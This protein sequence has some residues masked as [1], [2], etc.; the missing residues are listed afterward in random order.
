MIE[1]V[2]PPTRD[3]FMRRY[4]R[5]RVPVVITGAMADWPARTLWSAEHLKRVFGERR[6]PVAR[7]ADRRLLH[8]P[9]TGIPYDEMRFGEYLD[10]LTTLGAAGWYMMFLVHESLPELAHDVR[11]PAFRPDAPWSIH[12]F[13]LSP[14]D[15]RSP[16]HQDLP[17]NLFAQVVGRKKVTLYSPVETRK[18]YRH[19]LYSKLPPVSRVDPEAP[20]HHRFPRFR[21]AHATT[22]VLEPGEMLYIPR[23]WWH[24][25]RSLDFSVSVNDW[26]AVGAVNWV[27]QAALLY[28]KVRALRY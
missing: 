19:P 6:V 7:T 22:L 3:Q 17:E 13:W 10:R 23:L 21:D 1:R 9:K 24:Q 25:M 20:D 11:R 2:P 14:A 26:W 18:L 16:L 12:K 4:V 28:Q 5:P 27:V 15:T 8:D